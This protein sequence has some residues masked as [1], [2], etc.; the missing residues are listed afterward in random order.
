MSCGLARRIGGQ[1]GIN[2]AL[3]GSSGG[4]RLLNLGDGQLILGREL[5]WR[6]IP[7][8]GGDHERLHAQAR[9]AY[10]GRRLAARTAS[11]RDVR[12]LGIIKALAQGSD[13]LSHRP[14]NELIERHALL[15]GPG[16]GVLFEL[17]W[18]I[19]GIAGHRG[20]PYILR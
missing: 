15:S 3:V 4:Q 12:K 8:A 17:H 1:R 11:V 2:L 6:Q 20:C 19:E 10:D 18:E 13:L 9:P 7:G 5:R 16:F 14:E